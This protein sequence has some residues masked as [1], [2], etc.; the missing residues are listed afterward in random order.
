MAKFHQLTDF[1]KYPTL[2][3]WCLQ[4]VERHFLKSLE[5]LRKTRNQ[6]AISTK[7]DQII[8]LLSTRTSQRPGVPLILECKASAQFS[9]DHSPMTCKWLKTMVG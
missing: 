7:R 3:V 1:N 5:S 9:K 2:H 4:E 6:M 8:R